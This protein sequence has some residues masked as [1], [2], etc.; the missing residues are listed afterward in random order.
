MQAPWRSA[1]SC[2]MLR[3][4]AGSST[5]A[6]ARARAVCFRQRLS[7]GQQRRMAQLCLP[8]ASPL[9]TC[10]REGEETQ[11]APGGP[12]RCLWAG[13]AWGQEAASG[14]LLSSV[15]AHGFLIHFLKYFL[16]MYLV[17]SLC[18]ALTHSDPSGF[19]LPRAGISAGNQTPVPALS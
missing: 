4:G 7:R 12:R 16:I 19:S 14:R 17:Q 8:R 3:E 9:W 15:V 2:R 18:A 5:A 13:E 6:C 1:P 10:D 11:K